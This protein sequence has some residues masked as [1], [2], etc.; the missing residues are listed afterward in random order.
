MWTQFAIWILKDN[1]AVISIQNLVGSVAKLKT[2]QND[3]CY[4]NEYLQKYSSLKIN[5]NICVHVSWIKVKIR[6]KH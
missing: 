4:L 2:I 6:S 5:F 1:E 3:H